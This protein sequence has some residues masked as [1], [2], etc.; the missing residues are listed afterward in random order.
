MTQLF[1]SVHG[2]SLR[3]L[4]VVVQLSGIL[5]LKVVLVLVPVD[6]VD[7]CEMPFLQVAQIELSS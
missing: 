7:D 2:F 4:K 3:L 1:S 6:L 5:S